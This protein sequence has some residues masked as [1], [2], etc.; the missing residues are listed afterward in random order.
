MGE[1]PSEAV[2]LVLQEAVNRLTSTSEWTGEDRT[3]RFPNK[4]S[5]RGGILQLG[6]VAFAL[7]PCSFH[8]GKCRLLS[9]VPLTNTSP[10]L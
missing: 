7:L 8:R 1:L 6:S 3:C 5:E 4:G 9:K 2:C 10:F